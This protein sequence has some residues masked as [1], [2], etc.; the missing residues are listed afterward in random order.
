[1]S[2]FDASE[3][4]GALSLPEGCVVETATPVLTMF[5]LEVTPYRMVR[6]FA[7]YPEEGYPTSALVLE[8]RN[9]SYPPPLLKKLLSLGEKAAAAAAARGEGGLGPVA[10]AV[11]EFL[12]G[13]LFVPCWK[14]LRQ[15]VTLCEAEGGGLE[16]LNEKR[17]VA[18]LSTKTGAYGLR[19]GP[20][21]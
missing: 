18:V 20:H 2:C 15:C 13:N 7:H 12:E 14:E 5:R 10:A 6:V 8:V 11:F 19:S 1:M 17:G 9:P 21:E 16:G 4:Q 3:E